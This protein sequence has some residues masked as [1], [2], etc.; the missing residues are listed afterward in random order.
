MNKLSVERRAGVLAALVDGNSIRATCRITGT[1]K[2]TV[3][4]LLAE[5]GKVCAD[6]Q[7]EHLVNLPCHR[8]QCDETWSFCYAKQKNVSPEKQGEFGYGDAWTWV[9]M[10]AET[11]VVSNDHFPST[12]SFHQHFFDKSLRG[13]AGERL[14]K[15]DHKGCLHPTFFKRFKTLIQGKKQLRIVSWGHHGSRMRMKCHHH[16]SAC[17]SARPSRREVSR[18]SRIVR[19]R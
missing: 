3:L 18:R 6:Y 13:P 19:R 1:A 4:R 2:G 12:Q 7:R 10:D 11:K 9:A 15:R 16:W 14:G 5:I 17:Q 8:I